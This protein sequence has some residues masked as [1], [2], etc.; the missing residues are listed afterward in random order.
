MKTISKYGL[1]ALV[2]TLPLIVQAD[3]PMAGKQYEQ[4]QTG[5]LS[6]VNTQDHTV[7]VRTWLGSRTFN[8]GDKCTIVAVDKKGAALSDLRPG[9]KVQIRYQNVDGV[10]VADMLAEK[11]LFYDGTIS[12][13]DPKAGTVTMTESPLAEPFH[14]PKTFR[15]TDTSKVF[16][17]NGRSGAIANLQ[18][19]DRITVSY[20][21]P[22]G[23]PAAYRIR[24]RT[25]SCIG[26]IDV[27]D[28]SA[29]MVEVKDSSG[30]Q[31]FQLADQ[32]QILLP[33]QKNGRLQD[34]TI[35]QKYRLTYEQVNGINV[36]DRIAPVQPAPSPE[37]AT[38]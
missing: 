4:T 31:K 24:E 10:L 35:G 30:Q 9:I 32:C 22:G 1:L 15:V 18:P 21:N 27:I 16:L 7:Q 28:S 20:E 23:S 37:T 17:S 11:A 13:V 25:T 26:T 6:A 36:L 3:P 8:V 29:R 33:D 5:T 2:A 14:A 19:G 34:V 12:A 38:R